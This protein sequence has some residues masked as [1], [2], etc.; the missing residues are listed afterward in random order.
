MSIGFVIYNFTNQFQVGAVGIRSMIP[1]LQNSPQLKTINFANNDNL[2]NEAFEVLINALNGTPIEELYLERCSITDISVLGNVALPRL[3]KIDLS[4]NKIGR[5]G[6]VV[7]SNLLQQEGST[8]TSLHLHSTDIDDDEI[9]ILANSLKHNTSLT[10]LGLDGNITYM[11][12]VTILKLLN[13]VSSI[14]KTYN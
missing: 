8:L 14:E 9:E 10:N 6:V 3:G 4:G 2:D 1:F 11:G 7:L 5:D 13:D 12:F